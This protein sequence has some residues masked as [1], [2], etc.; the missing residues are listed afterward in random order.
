MYLLELLPVRWSVHRMGRLDI[1]D[2]RGTFLGSD[3]VDHG[4]LAKYHY[5]YKEDSGGAV[6]F[7]EVRMVS[8]DA[9]DPEDAFLVLMT[10]SDASVWLG[11][12]SYK[13]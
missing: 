7:H 12:N 1:L 11:G 6:M 4:V 9:L 2:R 5:C 8:Q 13:I 10:C 3:I